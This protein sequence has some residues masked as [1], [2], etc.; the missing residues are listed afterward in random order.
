MKPQVNS[1]LVK[2]SDNAK[3]SQKTPVAAPVHIKKLNSA[4]AKD[5]GDR[6]VGCIPQGV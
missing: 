1:T 6:V 3:Q 2:V 5:P 4:P